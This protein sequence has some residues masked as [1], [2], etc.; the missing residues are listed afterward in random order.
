MFYLI[1]KIALEKFVLDGVEFGGRV[2]D[3]ASTADNCF[4]VNA[5]TH[6]WRECA[7]VVDN[8]YDGLWYWCPTENKPKA[9]PEPEP[10]PNTEQEST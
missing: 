4:P 3:K 5:E 1:S 10:K 8:L 7:D 2:V 9:A 6:E